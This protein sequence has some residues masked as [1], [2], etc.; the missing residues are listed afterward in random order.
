M[1]YQYPILLLLLGLRTWELIASWVRFRKEQRETPGTELQDLFPL[2]EIIYLLWMATV[3][4]EVA[5]TKPLFNPWLVLLM[6]VLWSATLALRLWSALALGDQWNLFLIVRKIQTI[7]ITGPY[8]YIRH[9]ASLALW[10]EV[11][12]VSLLVSAPVSALIGGVAHLW[13]TLARIRV[14]E[15]YLVTCKGYTQSFDQKKKWIPGV[16]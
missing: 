12:V 4:M 10:L 14:E 8:Q 15:A 16:Y 5:L 11:I 13:L 9:P 2:Q 7:C 6:L 1:A 3:W